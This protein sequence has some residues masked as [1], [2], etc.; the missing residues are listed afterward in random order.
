MSFSQEMILMQV[1]DFPP[2]HS[3]L[4]EVHLA[5]LADGFA[6]I[7]ESAVV[8][9]KLFTSLTAEGSYKPLKF[10]SV[11]D[12]PGLVFLTHYFTKKQSPVLAISVPNRFLWMGEGCTI[13]CHIS[14]ISYLM[15]NN[16]FVGAY[17][18]GGYAILWSPVCWTQHSKMTHAL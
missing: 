4:Q 18:G 16:I 12:H 13:V 7:Q 2:T 1:V 3:M 11:S 15:V 9:Q 14:F 10:P 8:I 5:G 6:C 17:P